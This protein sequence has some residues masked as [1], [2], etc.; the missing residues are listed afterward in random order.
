M[1]E[2]VKF[3]VSVKGSK[4][5]TSFCQL[6][7]SNYQDL[8]VMSFLENGKEMLTSMKLREAF[9]F[10]RIRS[11]EA[12]TVPSLMEFKVCLDNA[13]TPRHKL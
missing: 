6:C 11:R 4:S 5:S 9:L 8:T 2:L 7:I 13:V 1:A 3:H 10:L 12:I